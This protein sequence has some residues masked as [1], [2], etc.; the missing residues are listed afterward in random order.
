VQLAEFY[1]PWAEDSERA[2]ELVQRAIDVVES[3]SLGPGIWWR[4][5]RLAELEHRLRGVRRKRA[6]LEVGE[7]QK[8]VEPRAYS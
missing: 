5:R 4:E 1:E 6:R 3:A 2:E 8:Q 7:R